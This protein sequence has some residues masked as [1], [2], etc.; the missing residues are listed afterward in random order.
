VTAG[1]DKPQ[2][3]VV[4]SILLG[5]ARIG[6]GGVELLSQSTQRRVEPCA[7]SQGVDRLETTGGHEPC[8]WIGRH[9]LPRPALDSGGEGVVQRLLG[10]IEV[11]EETD[12]RGENAARVVSIGDLDRL[13]RGLRRGL[14]RQRTSPR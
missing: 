9:A 1:E 5:H 7:A 14:D 8:A 6:R 3:V 13:A 11:T 2:L 4:D 10:E 12:E